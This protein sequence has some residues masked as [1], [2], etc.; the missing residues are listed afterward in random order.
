MTG[1]RGKLLAKLCQKF[2]NQELIYRSLKFKDETLQ[3]LFFL[4]FFFIYL[5]ISLSFPLFS[6]CTLILCC[7]FISFPVFTPY[8]H[9]FLPLFFSS[10]LPL[11]LSP[12]FFLLFL[13]L[14]L[15]TLTLV[16]FRRTPFLFFLGLLS[17]YHHA[18]KLFSPP[19]CYTSRASPGEFFGLFCR[20]SS[21]TDES[22]V[23]PE[24][25]AADWIAS[26]FL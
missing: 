21:G 12:S 4:S 20:W 3:F 7:S 18:L 17:V 11:F 8:F 24:V 1:S 2:K 16:S 15:L 19:C 5:F 9:I 25:S 10:C 14:S 6:F 26:L 13:R 23:F 22:L